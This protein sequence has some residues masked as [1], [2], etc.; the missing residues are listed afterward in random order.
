VKRIDSQFCE[1]IPD[2]EGEEVV[3]VEVDEIFTIEFEGFQLLFHIIRL[4]FYH[5]PH[6]FVFFGEEIPFR[7]F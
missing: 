6:H 3:M 7:V 2:A 5:H 1:V 4:V